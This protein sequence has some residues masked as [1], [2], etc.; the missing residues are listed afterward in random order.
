MTGN[1]NG[2]NAA[3]ALRA[4]IAA[5]RKRL[6][7]YAVAAAVVVGAVVLINRPGPK[8]QRPVMDVDP[9]VATHQGRHAHEKLGA[10]CLCD[11]EAE[12]RQALQDRADFAETHRALG[13]RFYARGQYDY[14]LGRYQR[15]VELDKTNARA[16]YG[17]GLVYTKLGKYT[18]AE[19]AVRE[20]TEF[21]PEM[22]EPQISLGVLA[23]RA[24]DFDNARRYWET[25]L[26]L[27][28]KN[29]YAKLL[30]GRLPSVQHF[31]VP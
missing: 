26:K 19:R 1:R 20:A 9:Q 27:D 31:Q 2:G 24:G 21:A 4:I 22:V 16:Y 10:A 8:P 11:P 7:G 29:D 28:G 17:M 13:D 14:A 30:L 6:L 3:R 23:Y 12:I 25:A 5:G 18:E 15:A